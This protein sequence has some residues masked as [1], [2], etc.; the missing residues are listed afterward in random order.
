MTGHFEVVN[1]PNG[2]R[3]ARLTDESGTVLAVSGWYG[4]EKAAA[5]GIRAIREIAATG[6]IEDRRGT[7]TLSLPGE[8]PGRARGT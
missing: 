7:P 5:S 2:G 8:T 3:R 6:L 4:D 1:D